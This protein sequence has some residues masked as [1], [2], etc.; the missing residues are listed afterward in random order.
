MK[1]EE[2]T[3]A[4][5][6]GD[7][8]EE[9]AKA[10]YHTILEVWSKV[11]EPNAKLRMTPQWANRIISTYNGLSFHD[12]GSFKD[13]FTSKVEQLADILRTVIEEDE[14]ALKRVT[15]EE[16][17]TLNHHHYMTVLFAWQQA[18]LMWELEWEW[19]GASAAA[20]LAAISEV[21]K[22]FFAQEGLASLLDQI[23]FQF[24]D[25]DREALAAMLEETRAGVEGQSE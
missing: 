4:A 19:A 12:M 15:S 21:H 24:D 14:E 2:D 3:T 6:A 8:L 20:E 9:A 13:R 11:L 25:T 1:T 22:M 10:P 18:I 7:L 5:E 23:G 16:D 17:A